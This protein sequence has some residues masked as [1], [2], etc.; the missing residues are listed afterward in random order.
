MQGQEVEWWV[1]GA[2]GEGDGE[3]L[4]NGCR[5][6]VDDEKSSGDEWR[7][8]MVAPQCECAECR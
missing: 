3:Q 8:A 4:S 6:C 1:P 2:G 7:S 5:V